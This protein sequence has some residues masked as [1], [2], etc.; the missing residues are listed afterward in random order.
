MPFR[1][2]EPGI[3][4]KGQ[5]VHAIVEAFES[6]RHAVTGILVDEGIGEFD[7]SG[8]FRLDPEGW[9]SQDAWMRSVARIAATSGH[10][11][12]FKIG[13]KVP[14]NVD[15]PPWVVDIRSGIRSLDIAYHLNHRK[16]GVVMFSVETGAMLEGIGHYGYAPGEREIV[17]VCN[18]PYPCELDHGIITAMAQRFEAHARVE[19]DE[20][21][22]CRKQG[23]NSCTY[24]VTW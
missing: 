24:V 2:F 1:I 12:L 3:E 19:H 22:P 7:A 23:A 18:T 14:E 6:F 8:A 20:S 21:R 4:I 9:I 16:N 11:S 13:Q 5:P 17:S 10:A 15:F